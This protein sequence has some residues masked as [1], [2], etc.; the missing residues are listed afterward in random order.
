M[1]VSFPSCP[2]TLGFKTRIMHFPFLLPPS[3]CTL[4]GHSKGTVGKRIYLWSSLLCN[5]LQHLTTI[6]LRP[7]KPFFTKVCSQIPPTTIFFCNNRPLQFHY[8]D[9]K[10]NDTNIKRLVPCAGEPKINFRA[11]CFSVA[12]TVG[13]YIT[14]VSSMCTCIT[15]LNLC[16]L[17]MNILDL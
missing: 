16:F 6:F 12:W 4:S 14:G 5:F 17:D 8:S 13:L 9:F 2:F 15:F 10:F 1:Y 3:H 11:T 7:G